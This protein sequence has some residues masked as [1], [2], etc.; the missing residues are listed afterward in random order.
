MKDGGGN[1]E[2][3]TS[4]NAMPTKVASITAQ[5]TVA[6]SVASPP[7][8]TSKGKQLVS[9]LKFDESEGRLAKDSSTQGHNNFGT[10]VG[11]AERMREVQLDTIVFDGKKDAVQL[12]NSSDINTGQHDERT[13]SLRFKTDLVLNGG[14]QVG[15]GAIRGYL[16]GG[17]FG[18][19]NGSQLWNH[20]SAY[21]HWQHQWRYALS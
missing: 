11:N 17:Q 12:K 6:P 7:F 18:S 1:L 3:A 21:R 5:L 9:H 20:E 14:S 15:K 2:F 10:L 13:I 8:S 4:S 16:N 19:G